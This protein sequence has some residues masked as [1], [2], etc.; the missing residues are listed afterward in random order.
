MGARDLQ[1]DA[2]CSGRALLGP[3]RASDVQVALEYIRNIPDIDHNNL[4]LQGF[5]HGGWAVL[6]ALS[7]DN[8]AAPGLLSGPEEPLAGVRGAIIW[9]PYCG[10]GVTYGAGWRADIPVLMLLAAA[11]KTAPPEPCLAAVATQQSQGGLVESQVY[12]EASHGFDLD[13]DW[14]I[15]YNPEIHA[16]A[17]MQVLGFLSRHSIEH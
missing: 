6:E 14:V 10:A 16:S 5:S 12:A 7:L 1:A 15:N 4:F 9:Y 13:V 8:K 11:D 3:E 2:V 17:M